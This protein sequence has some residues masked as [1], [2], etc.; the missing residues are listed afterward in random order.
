VN[1]VRAYD[2]EAAKIGLN[3]GTQRVKLLLLAVAS[4]VV[5]AWVT[6]WLF[7]ALGGE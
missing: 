4:V 5:W 7:N 6:A 3:W 2:E 1:Q